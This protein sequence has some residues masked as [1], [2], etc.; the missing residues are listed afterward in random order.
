V[1]KL[2]AVWDEKAIHR[3]ATSRDG[4]NSRVV[5][6]WEEWN[7]LKLDS[8][9]SLLLFVEQGYATAYLQD[10]FAASKALGIVVD[11]ADKGPT[12]D[13]PRLSFPDCVL[14]RNR[15]LLERAGHCVTVIRQAVAGDAILARSVDA[16]YQPTQEEIEAAMHGGPP[17]RFDPLAYEIPEV[18][19]AARQRGCGVLWS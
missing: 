9:E 17:E 7:R 16:G 13:L 19:P 8:G 2:S 18:L 5:E 15:M 6:F 11:R 3:L 10:A 4:K 12:R 1:G 14:A